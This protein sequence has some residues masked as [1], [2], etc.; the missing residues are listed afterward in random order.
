MDFILL[1]ISID[2]ENL[3]IKIQYA[4]NN[5][6]V[7][8]TAVTKKWSHNS[9][10]EHANKNYFTVRKLELVGPNFGTTCIYIYEK[11]MKPKEI[12]RILFS[13]FSWRK[14]QSGHKNI[15]A[16]DHQISSN[17]AVVILQNRKKHT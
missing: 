7:F 12:K 15:L 16:S 17:Y 4:A 8:Y 1:L 2:S 3:N 11:K 5:P 6:G 9:F 13:C 10:E 14:T